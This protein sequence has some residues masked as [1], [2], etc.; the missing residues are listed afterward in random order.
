[1]NLQEIKANF[2]RGRMDIKE[3]QWLIN[4]LEM[5]TNREASYVDDIEQ[6]DVVVDQLQGEVKQYKLQET[7][8][9]EKI[10]KQTEDIRHLRAKTTFKVY[11]ENLVLVQEIVRLKGEANNVPAMPSM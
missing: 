2:N 1:M 3:I 11:E 7:L 5:A 4:E 6:M 10:K 9:L 8:L